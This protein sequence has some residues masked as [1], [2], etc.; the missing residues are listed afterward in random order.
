MPKFTT[1]DIVGCGINFLKRE[2]FITLNGAT[3]IV[4]FKD[5]EIKEYYAT[6]GLHSL[7]ESV[8]FN[9]SGTTVPFKF[10]IKSYE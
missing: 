8:T 6:I 2:I 5:I 10:D 7:N 3:P 4:A 9:F 1:G